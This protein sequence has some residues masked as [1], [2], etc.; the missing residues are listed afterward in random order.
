MNKKLGDVKSKTWK[1]MLL[2]KEETLANIRESI[3]EHKIPV[4]GFDV[5]GTNK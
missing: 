5:N 1:K 2:Y 3:V 4:I